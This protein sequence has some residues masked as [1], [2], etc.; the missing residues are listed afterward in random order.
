M[1]VGRGHLVIIVGL[2]LA[3]AAA[4]YLAGLGPERAGELA[5]GVTGGITGGDD[6]GDFVAELG[7]KGLTELAEGVEEL[8]TGV[9]IAEAYGRD[10][11]L[12]GEPGESVL[13]RLPAL[14]EALL[15]LEPDGVGELAA[16]VEEMQ[17]RAEEA[18]EWYGPD[19][20]LDERTRRILERLSALLELL[21]A[22]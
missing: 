9:L 4:A 16:F 20:R 11:L 21:G 1:W 10:P 19:R 18:E 3:T 15:A 7:P 2:A 14:L 8:A 6:L 13:A 5:D 17:E 22:R 12:L